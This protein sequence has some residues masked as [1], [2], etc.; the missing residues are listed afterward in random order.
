MRTEVPARPTAIAAAVRSVE[1]LCAAGL[2]SVAFR[3]ELVRRIAPVVPHDAYAFSTV[4]PDTGLLT[5]TVASGVPERMMVAYC[6][7]FY[8][9]EAATVT[10]DA[11]RRRQGV[12]SLFREVEGLGSAMRR[13][14]LGYD[15]HVA[16]SDRRGL[17]G[18]MCIMRE[19]RVTASDTPHRLIERIMPHVT[20]ALRT[21]ALVDAARGST[22]GGIWDGKPCVLTL[23]ARSRP[24]LR[25]G[26][27]DAVLADIAD[28]GLTGPGGVPTSIVNAA[29]LAR[30]RAA[31]HPD[32]ATAVHV[33]GR[34]GRWYAV[35]ALLGEPDAT[36]ECPVVIV[37]QPL[38]LREKAKLLTRL[39]GLSLRE[40]EVT[41]AVARGESTKEI[42]GR[43]RISVHTVREHL[44]R[45]CEKIGV[46][47]RKALVARIFLDTQARSS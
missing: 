40:R 42:A 31:S 28:V 9:Y 24:M 47:G 27:V 6:T 23:D 26:P 17:W 43:L 10:M 7:H 45:A 20:R 38:T 2:D 16:I 35:R 14:G 44:D 13:A 33:R 36:G 37:L 4:D 34:S 8:P 22:G 15:L 39:Y 21:C 32:A 29:V 1:R 25:A 5:H 11:A 3:T 19:R 41:A 30:R 46:R 18:D 12:F